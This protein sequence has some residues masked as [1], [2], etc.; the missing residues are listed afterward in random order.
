MKRKMLATVS[1]TLILS[2][3]MGL[4]ALAAPQTM[5][6]GQVFDPE[7]YAQTYPDVAAA[8]GTDANAL[9]QHYV[10][11]GKAEGRLPY[12]G[13]STTGS[14]AGSAASGSGVQTMSDG[15][16]FDP[17]YYAQQN[18]DVVAALGTDPE[19]L[20]QHYMNNGKTEG[21]LPYAGAKARWS[22]TSNAGAEDISALASSDG[23]A[24]FTELGTVAT[25]QNLAA[26]YNTNA[27]TR[28]L[29]SKEKGLLV[30]PLAVAFKQWANQN[31]SRPSTARMINTTQAPLATS[32]AYDALNP[33]YTR[34]MNQ[35]IADTGVDPAY[36]TSGKCQAFK[37][38]YRSKNARGIYVTDTMLGILVTPTANFFCGNEE[39]ANSSVFL[40][41]S[42]LAYS[43]TS[44]IDIP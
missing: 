25:T 41:L 10:T 17:T 24:A 21:R 5:S 28:Y 31:L 32:L 4:S 2:M 43:G 7:F 16:L 18:P 30:L 15:G 3:V 8:F 13:N 6:D 27:N 44:V 20:Y 9:Y 12:A 19:V 37:I 34:I 26:I 39:N 40:A 1:C 42:S 36:I 23:L 14:A 22:V 33:Y 29:T 11:C 38:K 35:F